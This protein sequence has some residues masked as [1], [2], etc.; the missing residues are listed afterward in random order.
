MGLM[1]GFLT[2]KGQRYAVKCLFV[3]FA[4]ALDTVEMGLAG[5][6]PM[7]V[8][9]IATDKRAWLTDTGTAS[10]T[11]GEGDDLWFGEL[12]VHGDSGV[13]WFVLCIMGG[14]GGQG[15]CAVN[16]WLCPNW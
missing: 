5:C 4:G 13:W 9:I 2:L 14:G 1:I 3:F 10:V 7:V 16:V 6:R 11:R 15:G 8:R 12:A